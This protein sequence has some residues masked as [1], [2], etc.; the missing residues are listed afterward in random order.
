MKIEITLSVDVAD[1]EIEHTIQENSLTT[2]Y[3]GSVATTKFFDV[4][5][6][7]VMYNGEE[8]ELTD[9]GR[10]TLIEYLIDTKDDYH[11]Y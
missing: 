5:I 2:E 3:W 7:S 1:L 4:D 6:E 11:D 9:N 8:A 10:E